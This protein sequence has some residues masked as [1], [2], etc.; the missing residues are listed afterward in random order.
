MS[1]KR[2]DPSPPAGSAALDPTSTAT[3]S[4][5]CPTCRRVTKHQATAWSN[6]GVAPKDAAKI[7]TILQVAG[8]LADASDHLARG[9]EAT[10]TRCQ[11]KPAEVVRARARSGGITVDVTYSPDSKDLVCSAHAAPPPPAA[12]PLRTLTTTV[13]LVLAAPLLLFAL[14]AAVTAC[15]HHWNL[16]A[17]HSLGFTLA[18]LATALVYAA[19]AATAV[20]Y[21]LHPAPLAA[22]NKYHHLLI[23][24]AIALIALPIVITQHNQLAKPLLAPAAL[25]LFTATTTYATYLIASRRAKSL[26][27][28]LI[29]LYAITTALAIAA[30]VLGVGGPQNPAG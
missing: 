2:K 13:I 19:A 15:I 7:A 27:W 6:E 5:R 22:L 12:T 1:A 23:P 3:W 4:V 30:W 9:L 17:A 18:A 14:L 21:A 11:G 28:N 24:V 29:V 10:C 16:L 26:P 20:H 8:H 25:G